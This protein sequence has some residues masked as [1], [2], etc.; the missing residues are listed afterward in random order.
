MVG[1]SDGTPGA[2]VMM[3]LGL[4]AGTPG[5]STGNNM[6]LANL[7]ANEINEM[8]AR[9]GNETRIQNELLAE[10]ANVRGVSPAISGV[11][12]MN[13][14]QGALV[15]L[16]NE[17]FNSFAGL[18]GLTPESLAALN[19]M[20]SNM[21]MPST[22]QMLPQQS[23]PPSGVQSSQVTAVQQRQQSLQKQPNQP[24]LQQQ[25][26]VPRQ[27][28]QQQPQPQPPQQQPQSQQQQQQRQ[29]RA[30]MA[31][32]AAAMN[33]NR[34]MTVPG[35]QQPGVVN[36]MLLQQLGMGMQ[37][38]GFGMSNVNM[39]NNPALLQQRMQQAQL[40][41]QQQ[42]IQRLQQM[43]QQQTQQQQAWLAAL[44]AVGGT[45]GG[46][47]TATNPLLATMNAGALGLSGQTAAL[48]QSALQ[49]MNWSNAGGMA[50][51]S[52]Q[53]MAAA[54]AA[55]VVNAG[56]TSNL[57]TGTPEPAST[58]TGQAT[59]TAT[60]GLDAGPSAPPSKR[61]RTSSS[62][63]VQSA[64]APHLVNNE[65]LS[66]T[67][68]AGS[69]EITGSSAAPRLE[70]ID[71]VPSYHGDDLGENEPSPD[72]EVALSEEQFMRTVEIILHRKGTP[73]TKVPACDG[74]KLDLRSFYFRVQELGGHVEVSSMCDGRCMM[75]LTTL[76]LLGWQK[77][78]VALSG[79][80]PENTR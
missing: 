26:A 44:T 10:V 52:A 49:G 39:V 55:G 16:S 53:N 68:Q 12:G 23:P 72:P 33:A 54:A 36:P 18:S 62:T 9:M 47:N 59:N 75:I 64:T 5:G 22:P 24:Q 42:Q 4:G 43:Q 67:L 6:S 41:A 37:F 60:P 13:G 25:Q 30:V 29:N 50:N 69:P 77:E 32:A 46:M 3:N 74:H 78:A 63:P 7:P 57:V 17:A 1:G 14:A 34:M 80:G 71:H 27:Q 48:N 58:T 73:L 66:P 70:R 2:S 76:I 20:A 40:Q 21:G 35:M 28:Q 8:L 79:A 61:Q 56:A 19:S 65:P 15:G 11:P 31:A 38:N 51:W 45:S